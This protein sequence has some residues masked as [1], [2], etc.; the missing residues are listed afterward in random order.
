MTMEYR[1][2]E[3]ALVQ[4]IGGNIWK[5]SASVAGAL[6]TGQ[7]HTKASAVAAA[8]RAIDRALA[9]KKVRLVPPGEGR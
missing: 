2:I 3:Y 8:E 6:I 9:V 4:G 7:E 1:H 5:W